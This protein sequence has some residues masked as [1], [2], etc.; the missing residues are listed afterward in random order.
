[1]SNIIHYDT[2]SIGFTGA[3]MLIQYAEDRN[4]EIVLWDIFD[5]PVLETLQLIQYMM[6]STLVG[7]NLAHDSFHLARTF[8][9]LAQLPPHENPDP[10]E[11]AHVETTMETKKYCLKPAGA[12]DLMIVGRK[13]ELQI[14]MKQKPIR[15]T[16]VPRVAAQE[17]VNTVDSLLEIPS[18]CHAK[19]KGRVWDILDIKDGEHFGL[20]PNEIGENKRAKEAG[21]DL[22]FPVDKDFVNIRLPFR[23][24]GSLK[25]ICKH[26][27]GR[28]D[29]EAFE[30]HGSKWSEEAFNPGSG[31]WISVFHEHYAAW[32][33]DP[34]KREYARRDV[35]Y[36]YEYYDHLGQ[37]KA[38]GESMLAVMVGN[39]Y[40]SGLAIDMEECE[41]QY[42]QL[43]PKVLEDSKILNINKPAEVLPYLHEHLDELSRVGVTKTDSQ[44]IHA[45]IDFPE[46][47]VAERAEFIRDARAREQ[48]MRLLKKIK[49]VGRLHVTFQV[50][51]TRTNRMSGGDS[52]EGAKG[53]INPQGIK[54]SDIRKMFTLVDKGE[55]LSMGDFDGFEVSIFDAVYKDPELHKDLLSGKSVHALWGMFLYSMTYDEIKS[56]SGVKATED[57]GYYSRAKNSFFAGIYGAQ[58][59]KIAEITWLD[60]QDVLKATEHFRSKY[61]KI[62]EAEEAMINDHSCLIQKGEVGSAIIW[63][64]PKLFVET[65]LGFRRYFKL[66]YS[67]IKTLFDLAQDL[68]EELTDFD[69]SIEIWRRDR[70]QKIKGCVM[71]ALFHSCFQMMSTILRVG[72]NVKI[73][74]PGGE[75]TKDLQVR[76]VGFQPQGISEFH[77]KLYNVHDEILAVHKAELVD[78]IEEAVE[79]FIKDYKKHVP[80]LGMKWEKDVPAWKYSVKKKGK[81]IPLFK[82]T[83]GVITYGYEFE[84]KATEGYLRKFNHNLETLNTWSD[85]QLEKAGFNELE[86]KGIRDGN[87]KERN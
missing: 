83:N 53:S 33:H 14:A 24:S 64:D 58:P 11:Y 36:T 38:D 27:L 68:P 46:R 80:L 73:Q 34:K 48:E 23:P 75:I 7:F 40:W 65:F 67:I 66:E 77:V 61:S 2:E 69:P 22:P 13:D 87:T 35:E 57:D 78:K 3:T 62:G 60:E 72:G 8:N 32:K 15:F 55:L 30:D 70:P 54:K 25:D 39:T 84:A 1:M 51:G 59:P 18:I 37:P 10:W 85:I 17:L 4:R 19:G 6:N 5:K 12:V 74:S 71:S 41:K 21:L 81:L 76:L 50:S 86:I 82:G 26:I 9:C 79:Q 20:S 29:T 63:N 44:T 52:L 42:N 16:R 43:E 56:K 49:K 31:K 45:L 28:T 47:K